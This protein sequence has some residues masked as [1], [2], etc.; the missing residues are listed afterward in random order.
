MTA[1]DINTGEMDEELFHWFHR[2]A[3]TGSL[4]TRKRDELA[5]R[6]ITKIAAWKLEELV[7]ADQK[8]N[9]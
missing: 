4:I 1:N 3:W 5:E 6:G 2:T 7:M 9:A 8:K